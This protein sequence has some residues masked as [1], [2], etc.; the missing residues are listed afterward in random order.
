MNRLQLACNILGRLGPRIVWLRAQVK[1][2]KVLG[3]NR[4]RFKSR[5]WSQISLDSIC[6]AGTPVN[7]AEDYAHFK[8]NNS[9][10]FLFPL[11]RP[12]EIPGSIQGPHCRLPPIAERLALLTKNRCVLF[13]RTPSK[14][15]EDAKTLDHLW[16]QSDRP[17]FEI[18]DFRS[19]Q[20][21][22]RTLW[23]P[24]RAAWAI[25]LARAR[26]RGS[27]IDAGFEYW[28]W[29]DSWMDCCPPWQGVQWKCGQ[30]AAVRF[31]ALAIGFWSVAEHPAT[32]PNRFVQFARLAWATGYRIDEHINYARS[33]KN[34]HALSE[35]CGLMLIGHVFPEFRESARWFERGRSVFCDELRRQVYEDGSYVQNSMNYHRVMLQVAVV[36]ALVARWH[37]SPFDSEVLE[38]I[39]LAEE[40]LFHML[41]ETTGQPPLYGNN[42]GAWV[43][44]LDECDFTDMRPAVQAA[45]FLVTGKRRFAVGPWDED[46]LWLFGSESLSAP[47]EPSAIPTSRAFRAGGYYTMR[48]AESWGM[49][50]CHTHT[51]RPGHYDQLHFDLWWRGQNVLHDA[52]TYRYFPAEGRDCEDYFQLM[53]SHNI[54]EI[55]GLPP[56][57][58]VSRFLYFPWPKGQLRHF[59]TGENY[60]YFEG[61]HFDYDRAP[62]DLRV[63]RAIARLNNNLW[64]IVD[65]VIG[66]NTHT[67]VARWHLPDVPIEWDDGRQTAAAQT[68]AGRFYL[69]FPMLGSTSKRKASVV[70]GQ[71]SPNTQGFASPYY[72]ELLPALTIELTVADVLPFRIVTIFSGDFPATWQALKGQEGAFE[73]EW[74]DLSWRL[75][76]TLPSRNSTRIIS[77]I[78]PLGSAHSS[79]KIDS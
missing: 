4:W 7:N 26:S 39:H 36:A 68:P 70:S 49:V 29:V 1:L 54:V 2:K 11:G 27:D 17:W 79:P 73:L 67:A 51:D 46:L 16:G 10:R 23:E 47:E 66:E 72:G 38:L 64:V 69:T 45:H 63:R 71:M 60:Q 13:F 59:G 55:D 19:E 32:S 42:D 40:F 30:E 6:I 57:E 20:G 58:R 74:R 76:L 8:R 28:R 44:P 14:A 9:P 78:M 56:V 22:V 18:A 21:D 50:R 34:N 12:P 41:D 77:N 61:E 3:W 62:W 24:S 33:Q 43:L 53:R 15:R 35:A 37:G 31:L 65:D 52:G 75:D 25:D 5:P 48:G